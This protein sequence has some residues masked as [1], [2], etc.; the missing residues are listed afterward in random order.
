MIGEDQVTFA[1]DP[2]QGMTTFREVRADGHQNPFLN[3]AVEK[4]RVPGNDRPAFCRADFDGLRAGRMPSHP[5][6]LLPCQNIDFFGQKLHAFPGLVDQV[7]QDRAG[8]TVLGHELTMLGSY[9]VT[10]TAMGDENPC[11]GKELDVGA[12]V[13]VKMR[14]DQNPLSCSS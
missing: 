7:G 1:A 11:P 3:I 6:H 12:M 4:G 9:H 8:R 10:P 5:K 2:V 14:Q 13:P